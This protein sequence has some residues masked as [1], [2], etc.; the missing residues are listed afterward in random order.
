M[1]FIFFENIGTYRLRCLLNSLNLVV[2]TYLCIYFSI[3][4]FL[5]TIEKYMLEYRKFNKRETLIVVKRNVT[6]NW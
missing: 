6:K 1:I 3:V 4:K 2:L 5:L